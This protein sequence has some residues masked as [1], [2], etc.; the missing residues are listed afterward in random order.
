[1]LARAISGSGWFKYDEDEGNPE[2]ALPVLIR[3]GINV[4]G[5]HVCTGLIVGDVESYYFG[6]QPREVNAA[7]LRSIHLPELVAFALQT[8][9]IPDQ[10]GEAVRQ[11]LA[12]APP[13]LAHPGRAGYRDEH[14]AEIANQYRRALIEAPSRPTAWLADE[15]KQSQPTVRRWLAEARRRGHLGAST[16]GRAGERAEATE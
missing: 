12:V 9:E 4:R 15:L 13:V 14:Y 1:V 8:G 5:R 2:A 16:P 10:Y 7:V 6:D 3:L 11:L